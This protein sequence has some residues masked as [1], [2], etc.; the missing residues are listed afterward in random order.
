MHGPTFMAN[1]LACAVANASVNLLLESNW[2]ERISQLEQGLNIGLAPCKEFK[3]VADVRILGG[4]GV[5]EM[6][7]PVNMEHIQ[8]AFVDK[9]VWVRP[10]GRLV[11]VMPPYCMETDDLAI[12]T[13]AICEVLEEAQSL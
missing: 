12:L 8:S 3:G 7:A 10:F 11:Y 4:I 9:G 6:I 13:N 1:P 2:K 5:V